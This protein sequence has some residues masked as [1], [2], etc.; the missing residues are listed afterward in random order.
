[1]SR[2]ESITSLSV[3]LPY[4]F[5]GAYFLSAQGCRTVHEGSFAHWMLLLTFVSTWASW[6]VVPA[7]YVVSFAR[8]RWGT[9]S[10][11]RFRYAVG[12]GTLVIVLT[13]AVSMFGVKLQQWP[14]R[15]DCATCYCN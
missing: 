7:A 10:P 3:S 1:M 11:M 13:I 14:L 8:A 2:T 6:I 15:P 4:V 5:Y 12:S 9:A